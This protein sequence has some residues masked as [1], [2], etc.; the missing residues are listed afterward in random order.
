MVPLLHSR[1][2]R[3][4]ERAPVCL[5]YFGR[6]IGMK[7]LGERILL[8]CCRDPD[9]HDYPGGTILTTV[10]NALQF[11][12]KTVPNFSSLPQGHVLD[13]GCGWGHQAVAMALYCDVT[14]VIGLDIQWHERARRLAEDRNCSDRVHFVERLEQSDL[15]SF[16]VV[17]SCSSME[18]FSDPAVAVAL[19]KHAAKPG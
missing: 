12:Y 14:E 11:L 17:L 13:F 9:A 16:D 19:M 6:K 10:E 7:K 4:A 3:P 2:D 18:H 8:A 1:Y 15:G 5:P